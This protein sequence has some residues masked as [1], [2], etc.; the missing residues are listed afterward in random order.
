MMTCV[1]ELKDD[2]GIK[3]ACEHLGV[4]RASYY[5]KTKNYQRKTK[6]TS[7]N[8]QPRALS[9]AERNDI[10]QMCNSER[11]CDQA[12]ASIYATLLDEGIYLGS[13]SSFYRVLREQGQVHERRNQA[14]HPPRK[15][16]ELIALQPNTCWSWDI[17]KVYGPKKWV[18][19]YL[20]VIL[21][22][23]SR[24]VVGWRLANRE[25]S[26]IAQEL[27]TNAIVDQNIDPTQLTIHADNGPSMASKGVALLLCDLGVTK[28]H[29]R[30]H[31]SND[32]PYSESQF[33]TI[34]YRPQFPKNFDSI[35]EARSFFSDLFT[36]YNY[37]HKHSGIALM[38]PADVHFGYAEQIIT[39]RRAVLDMAYLAHPE[40]FVNKA[41]VPPNLPEAVYINKPEEEL[42]TTH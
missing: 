3:A 8:V 33:K 29:S 41:P 37:E 25:T 11:F 7:P 6:T 39:Q 23:Y 4:A 12:P 22:I 16:P 32:N 9:A 20:Y 18:Y 35:E 34:K 19:Y 30:P 36:W 40:R 5:A 38:T 31:V 13:I 1:N 42:A 2:V 10:L 27:I 24:Y 14:S 17:T 21:D 26:E 28:S 15:K